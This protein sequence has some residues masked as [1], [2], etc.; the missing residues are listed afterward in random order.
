MRGGPD[1]DG[2]AKLKRTMAASR[3]D[4]RPPW[5]RKNPN[6]TSSP[7][8]PKQKDEARSRAHAAGRKY[9]T[10]SITWQR[11][12]ARRSGQR[13][14]RDDR[15]QA[16]DPRRRR[17]VR[18]VL[19]QQRSGPP[20]HAGR[21]SGTHDGTGI[22]HSYTPDGRCVSL[23]KILLTNYCIYDCQ[24][25]VNRRVERRRARARFTPQEVVDLT[26]EFY[27]RNYIEG[28]FLSSG[29]IQS[30]DYTMEQLVEVARRL[31]A[32]TR[33]SADTSI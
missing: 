33:D 3:S 7:L 32:G 18:R 6:E 19:R 28:L 11:R 23:L 27:R 26:L 30:P 24:Y 31:R 12:G 22:C 15:R 20:R 25:C 17:Q 4:T 13:R 1:R 10:W 21:E 2:R 9:R 8:S 16:A 14:L 29:I 5:K